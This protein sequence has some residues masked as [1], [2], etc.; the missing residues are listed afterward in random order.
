[1]IYRTEFNGVAVEVEAY[2]DSFGMFAIEGAWYIPDNVQ[3]DAIEEHQCLLE[4]KSAIVEA[5]GWQFSTPDHET[6]LAY[7]G[8]YE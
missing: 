7:R 8:G 2:I 1:M 4:C 5:L 3:L 6:D